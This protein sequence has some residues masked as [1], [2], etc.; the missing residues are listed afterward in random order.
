MIDARGSSRAVRCL[1]QSPA[2]RRRSVIAL[3]GGVPNIYSMSASR[4]KCWTRRRRSLL[5]ERQ[6]PALPHEDLRA[7]AFG[8]AADR[9]LGVRP[10]NNS[11]TLEAPRSA[12]AGRPIACRFEDD[13]APSNPFRCSENVPTILR[14]H[15]K[16]GRLCHSA[17]RSAA[18]RAAP[19][20]SATSGAPATKACLNIGRDTHSCSSLREDAADATQAPVSSDL[21][22]RG[23]RREALAACH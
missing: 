11:K 10:P 12:L 18:G 7:L 23:S 15:P 9:E 6:Y 8:A 16:W 21:S 22:A 2:A 5:E 14:L 13:V 19:E 3:P 1:S 20:W 4:A 17:D